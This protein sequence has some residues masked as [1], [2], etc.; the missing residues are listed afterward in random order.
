MFSNT[1]ILT[2]AKT[3]P[4]STPSHFTPVGNPRREQLN[5]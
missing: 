4:L 5:V 2:A 3:I 1:W